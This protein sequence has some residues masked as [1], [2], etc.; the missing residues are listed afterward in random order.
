MG[1]AEFKGTD[2]EWDALVAKNR[3]VEQQRQQVAKNLNIPL[4]QVEVLSEEEQSKGIE[5]PQEEKVDGEQ[6]I[7]DFIGK[8]EN[9]KHAL[10]LAEQIQLTCGEKWFPIDKLL[11]RSSETKQ[12]AFQKLK[13]CE[14]FGLVAIRI[15]DYRDDRK[16][17][18]EPLYKVTISNKNKIEALD[19]IIQYHQ[20]QIESISIERN[21][22][23]NKID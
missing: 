21:F 2:E 14:L 22:L 10:Q 19:R 20:G 15:G 13:L 6:E 11:K 3:E 18:R 8:E 9:Q 12:T 5:M 17:F 1:T 16:Q 7:K 4:E 23:K